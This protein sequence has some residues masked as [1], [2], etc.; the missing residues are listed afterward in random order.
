MEVP[1][2][3]FESIATKYA[4]TAFI[5]LNLGALIYLALIQVLLLKIHYAKQKV[6]A[7]SSLELSLVVTILWCFHRA[8]NNVLG[9]IIDTVVLIKS[10][11][12]A[13][14]EYQSLRRG[15]YNLGYW[16]KGLGQTAPGWDGLALLSWEVLVTWLLFQAFVLLLDT[17]IPVFRDIRS[18]N[19]QYIAVKFQTRVIE[20][21]DFGQR[22]YV[23]DGI[24]SP[25]DGSRIRTEGFWEDEKINSQL[26]RLKRLQTDIP[27]KGQRILT[28]D[29]TI[30][31]N[32]LDEMK[33]TLGPP[34][35]FGELGFTVGSDRVSFGAM[36]VGTDFNLTFVLEV[37]GNEGSKK[38]RRRKSR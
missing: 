16:T 6:K 36:G 38:Q 18:G 23:G 17:V 30:D 22:L 15:S 24:G 14:P 19:H 25:T 28:W 10:P 32:A 35:G 34:G 9:F 20:L 3:Q 8:L 21:F 12:E 11:D 5:I 2:R 4:L 27:D 1:D 33:E 29:L 13:L 7:P 26:V 37:P 31:K